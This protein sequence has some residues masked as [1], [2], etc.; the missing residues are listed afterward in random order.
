MYLSR[1]MR[2][3]PE[4]EMRVFEF[5]DFEEARPETDGKPGER[6]SAKSQE[7]AQKAFEP[8]KGNGKAVPAASPAPPADP[9]KLPEVQKKIDEAYASGKKEGQKEGEKP[10]AK[11]TEALASALEEVS[12]LRRSIM[13]NSSNDMLQLVMTIAR[14][15]LQVEVSVKPEAILATIERALQA[16]TNA[17]H[18]HVRVHPDNLALVREKKPFFLS[19]ITGLKNINFEGDAEIAPGGCRVESEF[20]DVDATIDTQL[21]EI[22]RFLLQSVAS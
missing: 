6:P 21:E 3:I 4:E 9:L 2:D 15:V 7:S 19:R 18:F 13:Q 10:F 17:D 16:S 14:Q 5:P 1:I 11:T 20:G 22:R 8:D 12:R